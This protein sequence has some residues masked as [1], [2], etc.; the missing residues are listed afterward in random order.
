MYMLVKKVLEEYG[1]LT[2]VG[3][4]SHIIFATTCIISPRLPNLYKNLRTLDKDK[5]RAKGGLFIMTN[6]NN[7][8]MDNGVNP[9]QG[10]TVA[11]SYFITRIDR[12][13]G[14]SSQDTVCCAIFRLRCF[15]PSWTIDSST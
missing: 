13:M 3:R 2:C 8:A 6:N 11:V 15:Q 12:L 14:L 5:D 7:T 9:G 4:K 1:A 10:C